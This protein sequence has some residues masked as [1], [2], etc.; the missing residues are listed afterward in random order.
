VER[1]IWS[2]LTSSRQREER[3]AREVLFFH[4]PDGSCSASFDNGISSKRA[5]KETKEVRS[6]YTLSCLESCHSSFTPALTAFG[7]LVFYQRLEKELKRSRRAFC[8]E[9][10]LPNSDLYLA[11][12]PSCVTLLPPPPPPPPPPAMGFPTPTSPMAPLQML[13]GD[14]ERVES[15]DEDRDDECGLTCTWRTGTIWL[16]P[17][18][19]ACFHVGA[20][21]V[22]YVNPLIGAACQP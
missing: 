19:Q 20:M 18:S 8:G 11:S 3:E 4:Q 13:G 12:Q 1:V 2:F 7:V 15:S 22:E 9:M 17:W 10:P 6:A 21:W 14:G 16:F 5:E